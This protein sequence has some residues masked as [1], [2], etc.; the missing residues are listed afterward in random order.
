MGSDGLVTLIFIAD[1]NLH[2][3]YASRENLQYQGPQLPYD[4]GTSGG[5][6]GASP[7]PV[8]APMAML[9]AGIAG[10]GWLRRKAG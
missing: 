10:L 2:D 3:N 8:P 4:V 6:G 5:G 9:A 1:S 7:V